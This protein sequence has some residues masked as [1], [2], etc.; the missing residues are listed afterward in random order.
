MAADG[1]SIRSVPGIR[2][3]YQVIRV[4]MLVQTRLCGLSLR[5]RISTTRKIHIAI[6]EKLRLRLIGWRTIHAVVDIERRKL[7]TLKPP[8]KVRCDR[9][10]WR[11][12]HSVLCTEICIDI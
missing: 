1:P 11:V 6:T 12:S 7:H 5:G 3:E 4:V 8:A 2:E 9:F 10:L